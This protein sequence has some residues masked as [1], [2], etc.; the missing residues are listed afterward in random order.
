MQGELQTAAQCEPVDESESRYGRRMQLVKDGMPNPC[1]GQGLGAIDDLGKSG[2]VSARGQHE[3]P[4]GDSD[5]RD[6][7]T[8]QRGIEGSVQLVE[9]M[10]A[11]GIRS[12]GTTAVVQRDQHRSTP[13]VGQCDVSAQGPGY[14]L[15]LDAG[16]GL[17]DQLGEFRVPHAAAASSEE[18]CGFS[19]ITVPP[20]PRPMH[21]VVIP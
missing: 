6:V 11:Q 7:G 2:E 9:T 21:I 14:D 12:S 20:M 17:G 5:R 1:H 19:Q 8:R 18:K 3:R 16:R 13:C 15:T 4:S 10:R